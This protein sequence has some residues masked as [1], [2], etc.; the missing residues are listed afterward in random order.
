MKLTKFDIGGEIISILTKGMYPDPR[1]AI[2]E[3]IQNAIDAK[4]TSVS[5]KVRGV[6]ITIQ[7]DGIGMNHDQLRKS[8]R[9]GVSDK[10][11]SKDV[12]FMGIGIYSAFHL[13]DKLEILSTGSDSI[14]NKLEMDFQGM[15]SLLKLQKDERLAGN[16]NSE[17]QIDLQSI[18]EEFISISENNSLEKNSFP[19]RGT[20]IKLIG[21]DPLFLNE[22]ANF[23]SLS[24]YLM[25]VIP[26]HFRGTNEF[27]WGEKIEEKIKKICE[28]HKSKFEM[29]NLEL[30]VNSRTEILFR[31]YSDM[32]FNTKG[33]KSLAPKFYEIK[34]GGVFFGVVWACLN[35]MRRVVINGDLRGFILKKQG[36][37][38]GGRKDLVK[39]FPNT[40]TFFDRYIGEVIITNP[41]LL[42]NA[43]RN[44]L[45]YSELRTQ[46]FKAFS[47]VAEN[48]DEE[49]R[50]YQEFTKADEWLTEIADVLQR[51][52]IKVNLGGGDTELL[53]DL[54]SDVKQVSKSLSDRIKRKGYRDDT[55]SISQYGS[56]FG[57]YENMNVLLKQSKEIENQ[58]KNKIDTALIS[59]K[60][61]NKRDREKSVKIASSIKSLNPPQSEVAKYESLLEML[62]EI[63]YNYKSSDQLVFLINCLDEYIL[64]ANSKSVETYNEQLNILKNILQNDL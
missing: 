37:S 28:K 61:K 5:V 25:Q 36:F 63:G 3:Y 18:L 17:K 21:L 27:K 62:D 40:H 23:D 31:P 48:I 55:I 9:V 14:P 2:R 53:V 49:G 57:T 19:N 43:S 13:C 56:G 4:S 38:I 51:L 8:V 7:D 24:K 60:E 46:F 20:R 22:V 34:N 41:N 42:P 16:G 33:I 52:N 64:Q 54:I 11:P 15:K 39:Y 58:I 26:L 12:G 45:E 29:I 44:D 10:N 35:D 50:I 6:D 32:D 1:D 47:S 30:Q 59:N